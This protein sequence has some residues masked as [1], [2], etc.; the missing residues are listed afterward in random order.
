MHADNESQNFSNDEQYKK[1]VAAE[2][3]AIKQS[4]IQIKKDTEENFRLKYCAEL[5]ERVRSLIWLEEFGKQGGVIQFNKS[6]NNN[7]RVE[8]YLDDKFFKGCP[9][10]LEDPFSGDRAMTNILYAS[11]RWIDMIDMIKTWLYSVEY[12]YPDGVYYANRAY[13]I[14]PA[15]IDNVRSRLESDFK[16]FKCSVND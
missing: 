8:L 4:I 1:Q 13:K 6:A 10:C 12:K 5:Q 7:I 11:V 9:K 2:L 3:Q 16:E 14:T 15:F